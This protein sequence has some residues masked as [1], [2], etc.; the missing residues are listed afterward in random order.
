ME[1]VSE[2]VCMPVLEQ[3]NTGLLSKKFWIALIPMVLS[4]VLFG[5]FFCSGVHGECSKL[6]IALFHRASRKFLN[7]ISNYQA[8]CVHESFWLFCHITR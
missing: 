8:R 4:L 2:C 3:N 1:D 6:S 7:V 5:V